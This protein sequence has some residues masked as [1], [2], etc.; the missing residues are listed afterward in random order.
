MKLLIV[1]DQESVVEGLLHGVDWKSLGFDTVDTAYSAREAKESLERR[2]AEVM[3]CDIEM[4]GGSGLDLLEWI[5]DAGIETRCLFLTAHAK[6][7]YARDALRLGSSDYIVQPAPYGEI[8]DRV[9]RIIS[10][11]ETE[12]NARE[13]QR[14]GELFGTNRKVIVANAYRNMLLGIYNEDSYQSL[15]EGDVLP[16]MQQKVWLTLLQ[17]IRQEDE[18]QPKRV[19]ATALQEIVDRIFSPLQVTAV[20]CSMPEDQEFA[21]VSRHPTDDL[22]REAAEVQLVSLYN[23]CRE[24]LGLTCAL[25]TDWR[26]PL[27]ELQQA[28]QKL[29][30]RK[31]NNIARTAGI[32]DTDHPGGGEKRP[33]IATQMNAWRT[34][35]QDGF[36]S[37]VRQEAEAMLDEMA[38]ERSLDADGLRFFYHLFIQTVFSALDYRS[39]FISELFSSPEELALLQNGAKSLEN[40]KA[41]IAY[42]LSRFEGNAGMAEDD[43]IPKVCDYIANHLES[44]LWREE[45]AEV[46]HLNPDYLTRRFKKEMGLSLREY[47][48]NQKMQEARALI[49]STGLPVS[50]VAAKVGYSNFSH[51]S[52]SYKRQFGVTPQEDRQT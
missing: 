46:V 35:L 18:A 13:L 9:R 12:Q 23:L 3:L 27:P 33:M 26:V 51:F 50:F 45:L 8:A 31:E 42:A 49:R 15:A 40:M 2:P 20:V 24:E 25:Y 16:G 37:V 38:T 7:D 6:F 44:Q 29:L 34:L 41:L 22:T 52:N 10:E 17:R 47:V 21:L 30:R 14:Q 43:V 4:P 36:C 1:D 5:R 28:W 39:E 48:I 32:F 19:T 11:V